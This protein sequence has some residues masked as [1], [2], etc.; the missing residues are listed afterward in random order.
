MTSASNAITL[1]PTIYRIYETWG[2]MLALKQDLQPFQ[3]IAR[4]IEDCV[5]H[6]QPGAPTQQLGRHLTQP[7]LLPPVA[8]AHCTALHII[9]LQCLGVGT[10]QFCLQAAAAFLLEMRD[11]STVQRLLRGSALRSRTVQLLTGP[12][13]IVATGI[14]LRHAASK[15]SYCF[16]LRQSTAQE[17]ECR[18]QALPG[19]RSTIPAG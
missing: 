12:R 13:V 16:L 17:M 6:E 1:R 19:Q 11:A 7:L 14:Y 9:D 18:Q 15:L 4:A 3:Q 2:D 8:T 10:L 5:G